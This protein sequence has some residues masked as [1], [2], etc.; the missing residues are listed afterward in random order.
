[1]T[2][3]RKCAT[4]RRFLGAWRSAL[5]LGCALGATSLALADRAQ[6]QAFE[7]TPGTQAGSV[8][9]GASLGALSLTTNGTGGVG[10][11][12]GTGVGGS[13]AGSMP[14]PR[15]RSRSPSVRRR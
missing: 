7:G 5:L 12:G 9:G 3:A 8:T 10:P 15:R 4:T 1:M 6:A 11:I 14:P 13:I 2:T